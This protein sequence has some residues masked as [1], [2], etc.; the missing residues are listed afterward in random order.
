MEPT[1]RRTDSELILTLRS[2]EVKRL[3]AITL[4]NKNTSIC[5]RTLLFYE[6]ATQCDSRVRLNSILTGKYIAFKEKYF[7]Q[8]GTPV[9]NMILLVVMTLLTLTLK[10]MKKPF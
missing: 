2:S 3:N 6:K 5:L 7:V 1:P 10:Q 9:V 8:E 4:K